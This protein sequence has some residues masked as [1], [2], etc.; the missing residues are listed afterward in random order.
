MNL[1][2]KK[3]N[4]E[5][6]RKK[7]NKINNS[8]RLMKISCDRRHTLRI[9]FTMKLFTTHTQAPCANPQTKEETRALPKWLEFCR[10]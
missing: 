4:T 6:E 2:E 10:E 8:T 5:R 7:S 3:I 9:H 1:F